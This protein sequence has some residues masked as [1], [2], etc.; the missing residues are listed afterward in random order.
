MILFERTFHI[1]KSEWTATM[2]KKSNEMY[3]ILMF[4]N[5]LLGFYRKTNIN[6]SLISYTLFQHFVMA[7]SRAEVIK[8]NRTQGSI[9]T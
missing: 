6:S 2:S 8:N 7:A 1:M 4:Q 5:K 3:F 9:P